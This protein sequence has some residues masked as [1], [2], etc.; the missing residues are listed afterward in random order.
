MILVGVG[1]VM[2]AVAWVVVLLSPASD[3]PLESTTQDLAANGPLTTL[4]GVQNAVPAAADAAGHSIVELQAT[5]S[6]GTVLLVGVAVAEGGLVATTADVLAGLQR[7]D[8]VGPRGALERA[9]VVATDKTSDV[10]LVDVPA[11]LPVAPFAGDAALSAGS[12]DYALTF[13]PGAGRGVALH[14]TP[15]AVTA[16]G[17]SLSSGPAATMPSITSSP[18][19]PTLL[20]GEPLLDTNGAVLGI[21]YDATPGAGAPTFLPSGLVVGVAGELRSQNK[22]VHG[23]LGIQGTD[24]PGGAGAK[25]AQVAVGR[26]G[27]GPPAGG[28]AHH[29]GRRH[30][31]AVHGRGAGPPLPPPPGASVTLGVQQPDGPKDVDITLGTSS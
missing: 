28:P 5:T 21:L 9:M 1:A 15:G 10:A 20:A 6:H 11:D 16:I 31:R 12:A 24:A 17:A 30:P 25:V 8:M 19:S 23:W 22:V 27:G 29:G 14:C 18:A 26:A 3:H 4:A 2:A 13:V 7:L